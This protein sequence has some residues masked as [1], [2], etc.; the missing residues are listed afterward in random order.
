MTQVVETDFRQVILHQQLLEI[1]GNITRQDNASIRPNTH[2]VG[3]VILV[4]VFAL[5]C[6]LLRLQALEVSNHI[7]HYAEHTV[8]RKRLSVLVNEQRTHLS[9]RIGNHN[10]V[11]L[12]IDVPPT[13]AQCFTTP[14]TKQQAQHN[15]RFQHFT[16][17]NFQQL[18]GLLDRVRL[19]LKPVWALPPRYTSTLS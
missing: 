10:R 7:V 12:E 5:I 8:A 9:N 11:V 17:D 4:P 2:E 3:V 16:M 18:V 6:L 15:N 19:S 1:A 14:H 13:Q